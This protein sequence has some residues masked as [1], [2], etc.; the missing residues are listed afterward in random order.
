MDQRPIGAFGSPRT[1]SAMLA[2][3]LFTSCGGVLLVLRLWSFP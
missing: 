1:A 2:A 3:R